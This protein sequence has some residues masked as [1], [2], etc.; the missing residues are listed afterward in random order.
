MAPPKTPRSVWLNSGAESVRKNP[1]MTQFR[2]HDHDRL[3][4]LP[5]FLLQTFFRS[6]KETLPQ[7]NLPTRVGVDSKSGKS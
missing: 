1:D 2:A 7:W 4:A 6:L 5:Q 3:L